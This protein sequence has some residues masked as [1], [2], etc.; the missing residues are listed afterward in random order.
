MIF[1][2]APGGTGKTFLTKVILAQ[3]RHGGKIALAVASSGIAATLLPGSKTAHKM[4]KI[5]LQLE[6]TEQPVCGVSRNSDKARVLRDC[7]LI[8]WD[9]CTMAHR[10]AVEAVDRMLRDIR[11]SDRAMGGITVLFCGDFRQT[12]PV[13]PRGTR[14]DEINACL[15]S[16]TLWPH[17][18]KLQLTINMRVRRGGNQNAEEFSD[19][20][21]K[22]GDGRYPNEEGL[23][24]LRDDLCE[25]VT[26]LERL[27]LLVYGNLTNI[28]T[29]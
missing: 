26:S 17:I 9:E 7:H 1:L 3:L 19:L 2:D 10:K 16:S 25:I 11:Q 21:L 24:T 14:T 5:P 27:I 8:V 12:L 4:F 15:K 28:T 22:I 18:T 13:V 20:L 6:L 23:I 29:Q